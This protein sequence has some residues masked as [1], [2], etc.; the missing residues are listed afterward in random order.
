MNRI[1]LKTL[2][3]VLAASCCA[4]AT[5]DSAPGNLL[6]ALCFTNAQQFTEVKPGGGWKPTEGGAG[7]RAVQMAGGFKVGGLPDLHRE[8]RVSFEV[9]EFAANAK[10]KDRHWGFTFRDADGNRAFFHTRGVGWTFDLTTPMDARLARKGGGEAAIDRDADNPNWS[11]VT[12]D[13]THQNFSLRMDDEICVME[14]YALMPLSDFS[15]YTYNVDF[16]MRNFKI[17]ALPPRTFDLVQ[18]PTFVHAGLPQGIYDVTNPVCSDV[19][20][21]MFWAQSGATPVCRFLDR[22]GA[23]KATFSA[24]GETATAN[25]AMTGGKSLNFIR[26]FGNGVNR[27][28]EWHHI[29]FTWRPDGR[30][31]FFVNGIPYPTGFTAGERIDYL[32]L[33]NALDN[34]TQIEF[35]N[36]SRD[37]QSNWGVRDVRV[38]HRPIENHEVR[39]MFRAKMPI[40]MVFENSVYPIGVPTP[41][42]CI[43][44]PGGCYTRPNPVEGPD[45]HATVD[46]TTAI[47]RIVLTHGDPERPRRVTERAFLPVAN[48]VTTHSSVRVD[49][50]LDIVSL[51]VTLEP[52]DYRL[53]VTVKPHKASTGDAEDAA[54]LKTLFFSAAPEVDL[55][56]VAATKAAWTTQAPFYRKRFR[57]PD[58]ME[59]KDAALAAVAW[60]GGDYLEGG[61][62]GGTRMSTVVPFPRETLGHPCLIEIAWPDDKP[63]SFGLYMHREKLGSNRD[64]LQAG[65]Q[66]GQEYPSTKKMQRSRFL[67][68]PASTNYLFEMRTLV[69]GWPGAIAELSVSQ[70]DEPLPKLAIHKPEGL[71]GRRFGHVDEDQTFANNLNIDMNGSTAGIAYELLRY[72]GY[73]GQNTLHYSIARYTYTYGPVEGSTGNSMFPDRQGELGYVFQTFKR[74]HVDFIGKISLSNVPHIAQFGRTESRYREKG[75]LCLDAEGHDRALYNRG[76]FQ[77]NPANPDLQD[78]FISYFADMVERYAT[79]G[80]SGIVYELG[81]FGSWRGIDYGY[82]DWTVNAFSRDTG[83]VLPDA[84]KNREGAEA[85]GRIDRAVYRARYDFLTSTNSPVRAEWLRWR[86]GVVTAFVEKLFAFFSSCNPDMRLFLTIPAGNEDIYANNGIDADALAKTPNVALSLDRNYTGARWQRFRG[87]PECRLNE[88]LYDLDNPRHLDIKARYGAIPLVFSS[89]SYF[90]TFTKTLDNDRFPA[91][92]QNADVK[93][94]GRYFLK[95]LS[96]NLGIGD[97]LENAIGMQPLGTLGAEEETREWTQA[98]CALPALPFNDMGGVADP[99]VG[100]CLPTSGG[101]YFYVVNMHHTPMTARI[102]LAGNRKIPV[103]LDLSTDAE[104]TSETIDL[105]PYQLRSFLIKGVNVDFDPLRVTFSEEARR[106]YDERLAQLAEARRVFNENNIPHQEEDAIIEAA[107]TA[108]AEG[109]LVEAHRLLYSYDLNALVDRFREIDKVIEE[110]RMNQRGRFAV[111]C[112]NP[113]FSMVGGQLFSPDKSYDGKSYGHYGKHCNSTSRDVT[114]L[115]AGTTFASLYESEAYDFDGYKFHVETPGKYRVRLYMKCGWKSDWKGNWW[116][117]NIRANDEPLWN[118]LDLYEQQGGDYNRPAVIEKE[119]AVGED[120][121]LDLSFTCLPGLKSNSTVRL[122]NGIEIERIPD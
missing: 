113:S 24:G 36:R 90:E 7:V 89:A 73:T 80:L 98:F 54:Y 16:E 65:I 91:Y 53:L 86:A 92:F 42:T 106:A 41:V 82:D 2:P 117:V 45:I 95:E 72:Y 66:A 38:F 93:P 68:F 75:Y 40:D 94:W 51:P 74:N 61:L 119:V 112:G 57:K 8:V 26:K 32:L 37:R 11:T 31:R 4:A 100:R 76:A 85:A 20:G 3:V 14:G 77:A 71:P 62:A 52:G 102:S 1:A 13:I 64:R 19:G 110:R 99:V 69:S 29:A 50:P 46:L 108:V 70:I 63:R 84:C 122:L 6:Y 55:T 56:H 103:Y 27:G 5:L 107:R 49:K 120:G 87:N 30:A 25:I 10:G 60:D 17:E 114:E 121:I 9:R 59:L 97:V 111:N 22:D 58:D 104:S 115:A 67:F 78:L 43:A 48:G 109:R 44:A 39:D 79:N 15:F 83:I 116:V 12:L 34:I 118:S 96:F 23:V 21:I 18:E 28:P 81:G 101:T 35:P 105:L 47:E 88:T 33:G